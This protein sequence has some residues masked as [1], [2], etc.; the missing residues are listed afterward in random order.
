MTAPMEIEQRVGDF[1]CGPEFRQKVVETLN[2]FKIN[3]LFRD[4]R[5]H[6]AVGLVII[7]K[8]DKGYI[9]LTKRPDHLSRHPGQYALPG[10]RLDKDETPEMAVLREIKE[11]MGINIDSNDVLGRLDDYPTRSG[12]RITPLVIWAGSEVELN[13]DNNEVAQVFQIPLSELDCNDLIELHE[14][15]ST[16]KPI[17][18]INLPTTGGSVY[19]P[20][21]AI[22]YQFREV[23]LRGKSTRVSHF[24]QPQ[25]AWK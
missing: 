23:V 7:G 5:L 13:P 3:P 21:A 25:F 8:S 16:E 19:A 10:G 9:L 20:T 11:E 17:L 4:S 12:F 6:A 2:N 1:Y 24:D 15:G 18:S 14:S 22:I